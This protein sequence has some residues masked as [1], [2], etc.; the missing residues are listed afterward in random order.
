VEH[1]AVE[2][3]NVIIAF[4]ETPSASGI[5]LGSEVS[6]CLSAQ[7]MQIKHIK[8]TVSNDPVKLFFIVLV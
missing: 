2:S 7:E 3:R 6:A 1:V 4:E 8:S 5:L